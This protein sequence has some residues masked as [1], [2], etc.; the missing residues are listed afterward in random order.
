MQRNARK[1]RGRTELVSADVV[2]KG[3][4][5]HGGDAGEDVTGH[6]LIKENGCE[7]QHGRELEYR[8]ATAKAGSKK[9]SRCHRR[10]TQSK[11]HTWTTCN[12][13]ESRKRVRRDREACQ[14]KA[15]AKRDT[16]GRQGRTVVK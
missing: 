1:N 9:D 16:R 4:R 11:S 10:P 15:G 8:S 14:D 6:A 13:S 12:L 3:R 7:G 2:V 5:V